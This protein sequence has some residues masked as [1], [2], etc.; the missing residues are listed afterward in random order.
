MGCI[1]SKFSSR[2]AS[3][4]SDRYAVSN[5]FTSLDEIT[6]EQAGKSP[7]TSA[8]KPGQWAP[9]AEQ[10][11]AFTPIAPDLGEAP[12][13]PGLW[14]PK[15]QQQPPIEPADPEPPATLKNAS[16]VAA[17]AST[18][19]PDLGQKIEPAI[20]KD[21]AAAPKPGQWT[22]KPAPVATT[23]AQQGVDT[24]QQA[25]QQGLGAAAAAASEIDKPALKPGQWAPKAAASAAPKPGQWTPKPAASDLSEASVPAAAQV[26]EQLGQLAP[27]S[28]VSDAPAAKPGQW[29]PK[30]AGASE[31][32]AAKPGQWKPGQW[33][34]KEAGAS[35]A[36]APAAKPG[37]YTAPGQPAQRKKLD[38]RDYSFT[39]LQVL[40]L[41]L[42]ACSSSSCNTHFVHC[43]IASLLNVL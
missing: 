11:I 23:P 1:L 28:S 3:K 19:Y 2:S 37:Q 41:P 4:R 31:A 7:V 10:P 16:P 36:P 26:T 32:P 40:R 15:P 29:K 14:R 17:L 8:I 13:K 22:P 21:V 5:A 34:P 24:A 27:P 12:I 38:P 6:E 9:K 20:V 25:L 30:E 35:D 18:A 42:L 33:K 43:Y 39:N